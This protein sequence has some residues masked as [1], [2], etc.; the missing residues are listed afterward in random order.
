MRRRCAVV[1]IA[2][3]PSSTRK[4]AAFL[5]D[6]WSY[7]CIELPAFTP[8]AFR[9]YLYEVSRHWKYPKKWRKKAGDVLRYLPQ[10]MWPNAPAPDVVGCS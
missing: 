8:E 10:E 3:C 7:S 5:F 1:V 9:G 6:R 4:A 2:T